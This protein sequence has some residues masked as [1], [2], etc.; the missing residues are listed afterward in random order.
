MTRPQR[1]YTDAFKREGVKL[2]KQ[3]GASVMY[4]ARDLGSRL[5]GSEAAPCLRLVSPRLKCTSLIKIA[6][7]H[8]LTSHG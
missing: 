7:P 1:I 2:R 8:E 5:I 6:N 4:I 3:L